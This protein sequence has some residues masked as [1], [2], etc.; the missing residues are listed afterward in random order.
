MNSEEEARLFEL[1]F[2]TRKEIT[3]N[4]ISSYSITIPLKHVQRKNVKPEKLLYY[5]KKTIN[6]NDISKI[7]HTTEPRNKGKLNSLR[8]RIC[9]NINLCYLVPEDPNNKIKV[10]YP[11]KF[12]AEYTSKIKKLQSENNIKVNKRY[13]NSM[14]N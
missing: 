11:P 2:H 1:D 5:H 8:E 13:I 4:D 10:Q 7:D 6:Q 3:I 9:H 14:Y 12:L